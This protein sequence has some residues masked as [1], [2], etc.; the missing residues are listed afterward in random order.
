LPDGVDF[1]AY[2]PGNIG[3]EKKL[4]QRLKKIKRAYEK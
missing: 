2:Q 3:R 4:W 1:E